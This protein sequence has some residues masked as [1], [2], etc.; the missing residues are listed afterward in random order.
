MTWLGGV[1]RKKAFDE[2]RAS[3][4]GAGDHRLGSFSFPMRWS[5]ACGQAG[6]VRLVRTGAHACVC[7]CAS[8]C[9]CT[10][11]C[12]CSA[13]KT[14]PAHTGALSIRNAT[15]G[16]AGGT[17]GTGTHHFGRGRRRDGVTSLQ[18]Q[19][20]GVGLP[21]RGEGPGSSGLGAG[22]VVATRVERDEQRSRD[23]GGDGI[24]SKRLRGRQDMLRLRRSTRL[25]EELPVAVP[26]VL[27]QSLCRQQ[28]RR[29]R[30]SEARRR[31]RSGA[32]ARLRGCV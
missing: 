30:Q 24:E 3:K 23:R 20:L 17:G 19:G 21:Q 15:G 16:R 7:V 27:L 4:R 13:A 31:T 28:S 25:L 6:Q 2:E 11:A 18:K 26:L 8:L 32:V 14:Y 9:L 12:V 5:T 1:H 22:G 10:H 29:R